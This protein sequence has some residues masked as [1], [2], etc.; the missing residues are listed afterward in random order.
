MEGLQR[1]NIILIGFMGSG[2][3]SVGK[4]LALRMGFDFLDTDVR[5]EQKERKTI[6]ELFNSMGEEYFRTQETR[7]LEELMSSAEGIIVSTGG[8]MPLREEN[9]EL[10]KKTGFVVYL[11]ASNETIVGRL[12]GDTT[13][14]L[15][16]GEELTKKVERL[17]GERMQAYMA[18]A[19]LTIDTDNL[20]PEELAEEILK[21]Y[22]RQR[23]GCIRDKEDENEDIGN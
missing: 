3:T 2:K 16:R 11:K 23:S 9:R 13:R 5:I 1:N 15:L 18:A 14:P 12:Q 20:L 21:E 4:H 8:G 17:Q 19:H 22:R 6:P 10:L 7:L